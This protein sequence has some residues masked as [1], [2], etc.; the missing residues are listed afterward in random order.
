M[1]KRK[2]N[3]R[4]ERR[5]KNKEEIEQT[6]FEIK[7]IIKIIII[8]AITLILFYFLTLGILNKKESIIKEYNPSIEYN[9][10]LVGQSFTQKRNEYLVF[11][12]N[13]DKD[14]MDKIH[15]LISQ[16]NDKK[17]KLYL[18]SVDMNEAFN[19]AYISDE[20]NEIAESAAELKINGMT[21]IHF[22]DHK[23]VEYVTDNVETY[24][25]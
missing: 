8:M 17:D 13:S 21:I 5:K 4:L 9:K 6:S 23:I 7:R 2:S 24:L 12:Y 14:D 10:I 3:N 1:S 18:Y 15:S 11:Y 19:K 25:K 16:Y 20:S 22:K